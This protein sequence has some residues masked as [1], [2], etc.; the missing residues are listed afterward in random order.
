MLIDNY[1]K[2]LDDILKRFQVTE[3]TRFCDRQKFKGNNSK[4]KNAMF[5]VLVFCP[6]SNVD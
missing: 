3:P 1:M 6:S 2:F 4:R 5:M